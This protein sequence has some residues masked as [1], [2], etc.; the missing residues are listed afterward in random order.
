M[1]WLSSGLEARCVD[2]ILK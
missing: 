2:N 1:R